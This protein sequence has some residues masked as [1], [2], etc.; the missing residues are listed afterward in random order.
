[1]QLAA[2]RKGRGKRCAICSQIYQ[3]RMQAEFI[4]SGALRRVIAVYRA[5]HRLQ[6]CE[7]KPRPAEARR[8][9][10]S[11]FL[12][13]LAPRASAR[14]QHSADQSK[15]CEL[16]MYALSERT[17]AACGGGRR[18]PKR[19]ASALGGCGPRDSANCKTIENRWQ[20]TANEQRFSFNPP[21]PLHSQ[22]TAEST[23]HAGASR[24]LHHSG[25]SDC[26][27]RKTVW[28]NKLLPITERQI[29]EPMAV[30]CF[31]ILPSCP[32]IP[33]AAPPGRGNAATQR[34]YAV[35]GS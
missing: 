24:S 29:F 8:I 16:T 19:R 7:P 32:G 26:F 13:G 4:E 20:T 11:P 28:Q 31:R 27:Q 21:A 12:T 33:A 25:H 10:K 34:R 1:M 30:Q 18:Q 14:K 22:R 3:R 17:D 6:P 15:A 9:Y 5:K 35:C 2:T 23:D